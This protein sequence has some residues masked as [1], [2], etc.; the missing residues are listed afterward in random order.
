MSCPRIKLSNSLTLILNGVETGVLLSDF[1]QQFRRKNAKV[2]D[3]Y[4][5]LLDA[6]GTSPTPVLNP[7]EE[8]V[9]LSK[10]GYQNLLSLF[11]QSGASYGSVRNLVKAGNL[12]VS[13]VRQILHSKPYTKL[14][15]AMPKVKRMKVFDRFKNEIWFTHLAYV[16]K[17]AKYKN[18]VKYL[19]VRQDLFVRTV[20]AK[21]MTTKVSKE[22]VLAFFKMI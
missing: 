18:A 22:T 12:S 7:R 14:N 20:V 8:P 9:R 1:A 2:P 16:D 13:K 21:G 15:L 4:F 17:L 11:A 10:C 6:A 5:T 3:I 19:L